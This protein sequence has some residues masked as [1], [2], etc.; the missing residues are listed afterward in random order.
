VYLTT[1]KQILMYAEVSDCS[2]EQGSLRVDANISIRKARDATLRTKCEVKTLN[3]F[4][5]VERALTAELDRQISLV[6]SGQRITQSTLLFNAG[7]GQGRFLRSKEA[8]HD[9]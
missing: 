4:A 6:E 7:T 2:M 9:D 5:N 3:S 1:L 8:S